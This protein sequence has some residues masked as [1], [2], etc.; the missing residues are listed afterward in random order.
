MP[1]A[2]TPLRWICLSGALGFVLGIFVF[3]RPQ[4]V[5]S[6]AN[7]M[8][9]RIPYPQGSLVHS[10]HLA[11]LS[12]WFEDV[13]IALLR[14][15]CEEH[16]VHLLFSGIQSALVFAAVTAASFVFSASAPLA[17]L[18]PLVISKICA[19]G[20]PHFHYL[21]AWPVHASVPGSIAM[22]LSLLVFSLL[23]LGHHELGFFLLG[24]FL[25]VHPPLALFTSL[26]VVSGFWVSKAPRP[27][28]RLLAA[29][30]PGLLLAVLT[31][32]PRLLGV[33]SHRPSVEAQGLMAA[34]TRT[35]GHHWDPIGFDRILFVVPCFV[36]LGALLFASAKKT[37]PVRFLSG[38]YLPVL[39]LALLYVLLYG[40]VIPADQVPQT[41]KT[42]M[43]NRWLNLGILVLPIAVAGVLLERASRASLAV[44]SLLIGLVFYREYWLVVPLGTSLLSFAKSLLTG[45]LANL[46]FVSPYSVFCLV[47]IVGAGLIVF[48]GSEASKRGGP[49]QVMNWILLGVL[50]LDLPAVVWKHRS[51]HSQ[52]GRAHV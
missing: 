27:A 11:R 9:G 43:M 50:C 6:V 45:N 15:G 48:R 25:S 7:L 2:K 21:I 44:L 30:I 13:P 42:L 38:G 17:L 22:A 46:R 49:N 47:G 33:T 23:A 16:T 40:H 52:I 37:A 51:T 20:L 29:T 34:F 4:D 24:L 5:V 41:V 26:L 18:L 1:V 3:A 8:S 19:F 14:M 36:V 12:F 28:R 32:V 39:S 31:T 35:W 10:V